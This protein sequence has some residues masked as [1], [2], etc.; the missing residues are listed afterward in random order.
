MRKKRGQGR[1]FLAFIV[2]PLTPFLPPSPSGEERSVA[3]FS[4]A[5][6]H[7]GEVAFCLRSDQGS[8]FLQPLSLFV[9]LRASTLLRRLPVSSGANFVPIHLS[10]AAYCDQDYS[11]RTRWFSFTNEAGCS[12]SS[13]ATCNCHVKPTG[14]PATKLRSR[15]HRAF[16]FALRR[17]NSQYSRV[18][19]LRAIAT[20]AIDLP[21]RSTRR[22]Y[23]RLNS[24][25]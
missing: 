1:R 24:A 20:F 5:S 19:S 22:Q 3:L 25:S 13:T 4:G 12:L 16:A 6:F 10:T 14:S 2:R 9:L 23:T 11:N 7:R 8:H 15:S 18:S 21:R 17:R